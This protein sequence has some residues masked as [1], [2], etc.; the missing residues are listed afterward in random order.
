[1]TALHFGVHLASDSQALV[2]HGE[3]EVARVTF[4]GTVVW[5]AGGADVLTEG[6][7]IDQGV[8]KVIDFDGRSYSFDEET[9]REI[10]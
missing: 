10:A 3:L 4:D 8:V 7:L 6:F 2:S 1:L 9:G 5:T